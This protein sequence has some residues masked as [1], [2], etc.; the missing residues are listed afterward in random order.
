MFI[1]FDEIGNSSI[2]N[3][4]SASPTDPQF[5][6]Y[7]QEA[8]SRLTS[9]GDWP[10][11]VVPMRT[12]VINGCIVWPRHVAAV[13]KMADCN[14]NFPIH[15]MFYDFLDWR[16]RDW[17]R[18]DYWYGLG[19]RGR[20]NMVQKG[21]SPVFTEPCGNATQLRLYNQYTED[22][23]A[24]LTVFGKDNYGNRLRTRNV[25]G[26]TW[27]DGLILTA[28]A[29]WCQSPGYVAHIERV[30]KTSTQGNLSLFGAS[31]QTPALTMFAGYVY[32]VDDGSYVSITIVMSPLGY[33]TLQFNMAYP[34]NIAQTIGYFYNYD[35]GSWQNVVA[36]GTPGNYYLEFGGAQSPFNVYGT[37]VW[38]PDLQVWQSI[39]LRNTVQS[40][41]YL[42]INDPAALP[43]TTV[44]AS[45]IT[46][47]LQPLAEYEPSETNPKFVK[48]QLH[49]GRTCWQNSPGTPGSKRG[50]TV[51]ALVKL[52]QLPLIA[53]SDI[54]IIQSIPAI[55][56]MVQGIVAGEGGDQKG[57]AEYT[58][59]AVE[60]LNRDL[61]DWIPDEQIPVDLG[62]LGHANSIGRQRC[63]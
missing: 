18:D 8:I 11:T 24:T 49:D 22:I 63:F 32:N 27:S 36:H 1:T 55:K 10:G 6:L 47:Q 7:I 5:A 21:W 23:G 40:A 20:R 33:P 2:S 59:R 58:L 17:Y 60:Q 25:D 57:E 39:V 16:N 28:Q 35:M 9:R 44:P 30:I 56:L 37:Q 4:T 46:V 52:K 34:P 42:D 19:W 54:V 3:I 51:T 43:P 50:H 31:S 14:G 38:N 26:I 12:C 45:A 61:E 29:P 53:P 15:G 41:Q 48:M 62:E 13:R